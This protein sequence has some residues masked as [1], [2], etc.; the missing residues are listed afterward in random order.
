MPKS[1]PVGFRIH[2][3]EPIEVKMISQTLVDR[4]AID[5]L[6]RFKGLSTY[7]VEDDTFYYLSNG[8]T[9]DHWKPVVK[10]E[11]E[12]GPVSFSY[13][14][15]WIFK[16]NKTYTL[17]DGGEENWLLSELV[18]ATWRT[19]DIKHALET[20]PDDRKI[21][22]KKDWIFKEGEIIRMDLKFIYN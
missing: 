22:L 18:S 1:Y 5:F 16:G 21:I 8:I 7:V 17:P 2:I 12:L 9:N 6:E 3:P 20:Y 15:S 10:K 4:N 13:P 14:I 11:S 19:Q